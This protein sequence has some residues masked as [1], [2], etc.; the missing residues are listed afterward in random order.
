MS[1]ST[2]SPLLHPPVKRTDEVDFSGPLRSY[3]AKAYQEDPDKYTQEIATLHRLR[4]DSRG[5][6]KDLTGRDILYRYYGQLDFLDLRFPINE[7]GVKI[8]FTW[9]D[10][11]TQ[12]SVSQHSIAYEKAC[13]IFNIAAVMSSIAALQNRFDP[14]GLKTAFNY[15]QASAGLFQYINENFL[16]APSV[17]LSRDSI[18]ALVDLMLAQAQEVFIEKVTI[19]SKKGALVAKLAAQASHWYSLAADGLAGDAVKG[20]FDRAWVELAKVT[21]PLMYSYCSVY[22]LTA[23]NT[24][25]QI[26][27]KHFDALAHYH[28]SLHL[29]QESKYGECVAHITKAENLAKE[30]NKMS[31]SFNNSH[32]SFTTYVIS[33][34]GAG[35]ASANSSASA[36]ILEHTKFLLSVITERKNAVT[37][38]NDIIYH[39]SVPSVDTLAAVEKVSAAKPIT[40]AEVCANGAADIPHIIGADIFHRLIPLA[41]HEAASMYSE[42]KAKIL[43]AEQ[44]AVD[45]ANAD[46]HASLESMNLVGTLE[47][48]KRLA[49]GGAQS[50]NADDD[51]LVLP[52]EVRGWAV[53]IRSE[54]TQ[55]GTSTDE[56]LG[57]LDGMKKRVKDQLDEIGVLLDREQYECEQQRIKY[58]NQWT[59]EPS[60]KLTSQIRLDIRQ[61]RESFE[62][63]LATDQALVARLNDVR[64]ET[65]VLGRPLEEI[66]SIFAERVMQATPPPDKSPKVGNLL[67]DIPGSTGSVNGGLGVLEEQIILEKIDNMMSRLRGLKNERVA[68]VAELKAKVH[69]DDISNVLLA[70][71]NKETLVFQ[72][73]LAKFKPLQA[74]IATNIQVHGQVL[75]DLTNEFSKLKEASKGMKMLEL[76]SKRRKEIVKEWKRG[77]DLWKEGKD[78]LR[79]GL[80]F[81]TD[82]N[83]IVLSLRNTVVGF[84]NRRNDERA[85][86][87]KR[88]DEDGQHALRSQLE[89]LTVGTP[90]GPIP[91]A[92]PGVGSATAPYAPVQQPP[93][94]QMPVAGTP[95]YA[96]SS[97]A[98]NSQLSQAP[99]PSASYPPYSAP[100]PTQT[101]QPQQAAPQPAYNM[102]GSA[103]SLNAQP[104]SAS[105]SMSHLPSSP[106]G[107]AGALPVQPFAPPAVSPTTAAPYGQGPQQQPPPQ[108]QYGGSAP[109][110]QTPL[111]QASQ[112]Q[113]PQQHQQGS[114]GYPGSTQQPTAPQHQQAPPQAQAYPGSLQ[115]HPSMSGSNYGGQGVAYGAQQAP[116]PAPQANG[117]GQQQPGGYS[118]T[119]QQ[120]APPTGPIY[121]QPPSAQ[122]Q[123]GG[124][125]GHSAPHQPTPPAPFGQQQPYGQQPSPAPGGYYHSPSSATQ[126]GGGSYQPTPPASQPPGGLP[127]I[128]PK[129]PATSQYPPYEPSPPVR[130][131][132]SAYGQASPAQAGYAGSPKPFGAFG[133]PQQPPQSQQQWGGTYGAPAGY[134]TPNA[135]SQVPPPPQPQQLP[136]AQQQGG[137]YAGYA[138]Y[139]PGQIAAQQPP[140]QQQPQSGYQGGYQAGYGAQPPQQQQQQQPQ[141][142]DPRRFSVPGAAGQQGYGQPPQPLQQQQQ[143]PSQQV[144]WNPQQPQQQQ[145]PQQGMYGQPPQQ[146]PQ[147]GYGQQPPAHQ[148]QQY[149]QQP[150]QQGYPQQS[151]APGGYAPRPPQPLQAPMRPQWGGAGNSL[152]D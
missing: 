11:F 102:Y 105:G 147:Q 23:F 45:T 117:Y 17:D 18:K 101:A 125:Y 114:H 132:G 51:A 56:I 151:Q 28:R 83:D 128:P 33:P 81:Y 49:R 42:E 111:Q 106:P 133:Q 72:A 112:Q 74:K 44:A 122:G 79:K 134:G 118:Q 58:M 35:S 89:K 90:T 95:S 32:S 67:E 69:Q 50:V 29:E 99:T 65:A 63:A 80:Q 47:K 144:Y 146:P 130:P 103:S 64:R 38:D 150:P 129:V 87:M 86:I 6:G 141:Q 115:R 104:R 77:F 21:G 140:Q 4:Q 27:T 31:T 2:L 98:Y 46:L 143:P 22:L 82:L 152:L 61:N 137:G 24:F 57:A 13:T 148:Q 3:I 107:F 26:K 96:A 39:D 66:E 73:E 54:E 9:Y 25:I 121:G 100:P 126:Y 84:V 20:Q 139:G 124:L 75:S 119:Q 14:A 76:R 12:K 78:G 92:P 37:K 40:F 116:S 48:L 97:P 53:Q 113:P 36:A 135:T 10:A 145:P 85:T 68:A 93:P 16:H 110:V 30:A 8:S 52:G 60:A 62:K 55:R 5:A 136:P 131:P 120:G 88:I 108:P 138:A 15:L 127:P 71:K 19:E 34:G 149:G 43:R 59:Q 91:G 7:G 94:Q 142:Q 109:Y 1:A 70:H 123:P 41:V